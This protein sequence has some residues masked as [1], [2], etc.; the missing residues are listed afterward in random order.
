MLDLVGLLALIMFVAG[1]YQVMAAGD[2][3]KALEEGKSRMS[4][5]ILGFLAFLFFGWI[6]RSI[7]GME[8]ITLPIVCHI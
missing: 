3:P 6:I 4:S 8:I 7:L 2:D 5:A 1:G